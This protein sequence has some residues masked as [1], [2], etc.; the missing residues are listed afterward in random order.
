MTG[1]TTA[2]DSLA[3]FTKKPPEGGAGGHDSASLYGNHGLRLKDILRS[4]LPF[5][6][7][8]AH[9]SLLGTTPKAHFLSETRLE[10]AALS[11]FRASFR[12]SFARSFARS[13]ADT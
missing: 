6:S 8:H 9:P 12:F 11:L 10:E 5:P 4:V 3:V 2:C 7:T 1:L 13:L